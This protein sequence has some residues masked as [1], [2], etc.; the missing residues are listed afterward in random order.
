MR[1]AFSK[2][3][4]LLMT[5][6]DIHGDVS[7]RESLYIA[8]DSESRNVRDSVKYDA[9]DETFIVLDVDDNNQFLGI[10]LV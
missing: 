4:D 8:F 1:I 10:E 2:L 9:T 7:P 6:P 3:I 5:H